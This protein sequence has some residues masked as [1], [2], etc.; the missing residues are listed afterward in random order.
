MNILLTAINNAA[1]DGKISRKEVIQGLH[2]I[3]NYRG[4]LG[5][6]ITFNEK[7]DLKGGATYF[8]RVEGK[9]FK[10]VA[11]MGGGQ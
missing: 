10:Q 4:I 1:K 9:D 6:P 11:I 2:K 5:F 3:K 8:F 7:G